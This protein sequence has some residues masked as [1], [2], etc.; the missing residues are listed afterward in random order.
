MAIIQEPISLSSHHPPSHHSI[1]LIA[2]AVFGLALA[3]VSIFAY[4][5]SKALE[6]AKSNISLLEEQLD[7]KAGQ[8]GETENK[9]EATEEMANYFS[10]KFIELDTIL[11]DTD[12]N[13][14]D[15]VSW[16]Y[17]NA[18]FENV[19][20]AQAKYDAW[21]KEQLRTNDAYE[22]LTLELEQYFPQYGVNYEGNIQ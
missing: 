22:K 17:D 3:A 1:Y 13:S 2:V 20:E 14:V 12:S 9:L 8:V 7:L 18:L 11:L 6:D 19:S 4:Q 15:F 16:V 10:E 5:T 21:E